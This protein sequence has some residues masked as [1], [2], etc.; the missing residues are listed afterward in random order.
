[1]Q[2]PVSLLGASSTFPSQAPC[3]PNGAIAHRS[4]EK[5]QR[6]GPWSNFLSLRFNLCYVFIASPA[7]IFVASNH[8]SAVILRQSQTWTSSTLPFCSAYGIWSSLFL[9]ENIPRVTPFMYKYNLRPMGTSSTCFF[10]ALDYL[11]PKP[12]PLDDQPPDFHTWDLF[13]ASNVQGAEGVHLFQRSHSSR[14]I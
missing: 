11:W 8:P 2:V 3:D 10:S 13:F 1:M 9:G 5:Q 7:D 6:R 14:L 12:P 4:G